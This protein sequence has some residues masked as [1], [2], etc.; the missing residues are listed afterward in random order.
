MKKALVGV[1]REELRPLNSDTEPA[2]HIPPPTL[3][4]SNAF[5]MCKTKQTVLN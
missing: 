1:A 3:F 5:D 4:V 2:M